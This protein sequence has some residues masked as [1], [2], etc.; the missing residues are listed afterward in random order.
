MKFPALLLF[1]AASATATAYAA[2]PDATVLQRYP[3]G[4]DGGWDYLTIDPVAHHLLIARGNRVMVVD[5]RDGKLA[6]EIPGMQH[7]HGIALV[8]K[9]R[10]GYVTDGTANSVHVIDLDTLK[11]L[12]DISVGGKGPDGIVFDPAT[13]HVLTM[14][15]HSGNAS[16]IDTASDK[17]VADIALPGRPEFAVSDGRGHVFVNIEDKNELARVDTK[18]N[19]VDAVWKLAPCDSP[20]GLAIDAHSRRLFSVCDNKLMVITDAD[21]GHQVAT[22]AIG[23]GPD[24]ARF[25]PATRLAYSSNHD[26]TLTIV[27]EDDANH[28]SV[29]ANVPTQAGARTMA[30]D[31]ATHRIWLVAA[32]PA[33]RH[34]PVK[35]FTALVVGSH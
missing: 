26:G 14:N 16:V 32:A 13:G 6:G 29:V 25:D 23:D 24:A 35:D 9:S 4:G 11:T 27:H 19:K 15:G 33:P 31:Q 21:D 8:Q 7:I 3:L 34:A 22:A 5:T 20:S 17:A 10:H 18:A 28:Y 30:L 12:H 2:T 1:L